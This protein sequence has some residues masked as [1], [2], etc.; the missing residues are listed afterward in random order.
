MSCIIYFKGKF[1]ILTK[2]CFEKM[3]WL[4]NGHWMPS[5][6]DHNNNGQDVK[7]PKASST[8]QDDSN[9]LPKTVAE[10]VFL[11][12]FAK[13]EGE[14]EK[15]F[16]LCEH[17]TLPFQDHYLIIQFWTCILF[18]KI[19][20]L[21]LK[22]HRFRIFNFDK[23]IFYIILVFVFVWTQFCSFKLQSYSGMSN[24]YLSYLLSYIS[25]IF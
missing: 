1:K 17:T 19:A 13:K 6:I 25:Y 4:L 22:Y 7:W 15:Y 21:F 10:P 11:F 9:I 16:D 12:V 14:Q 3:Y 23:T 18:S 5:T 24:Y 20:N 8:K 2:F